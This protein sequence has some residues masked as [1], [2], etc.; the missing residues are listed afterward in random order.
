MFQLIKVVA[1]NKAFRDVGFTVRISSRFKV[2]LKL[3]FLADRIA[4][5]VCT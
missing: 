5:R 2:H 4:I 3:A 1:F